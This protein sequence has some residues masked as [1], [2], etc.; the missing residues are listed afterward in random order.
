MLTAM[1]T[2]PAG[3]CW[4]HSSE[5]QCHLAVSKNYELLGVSL[6]RCLPNDW[7]EDPQAV[8]IVADNG[9]ATPKLHSL[10]MGLV[11]PELAH[12]AELPA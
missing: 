7:G 8:A 2:G 5:G 6:S 12:V 3:V 10:R 9:G 1:G 4:D 11:G